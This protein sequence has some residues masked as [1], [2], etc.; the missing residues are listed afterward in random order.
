MK[1]FLTRVP[2]FV[3][4][5]VV[6]IAGTVFIRAARVTGPPPPEPRV[7]ISLDA[8]AAHLGE[9]IRFQTVTMQDGTTDIAAFRRL[10]EYLESADPFVHRRLTR[11]TV[12]GYSLLIQLIRN[13][14]EI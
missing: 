5:F 1:R 6:A 12:G 7:E 8:A 13:S 10:N 3:G 9:A 14:E 11:E 4:A 2:I